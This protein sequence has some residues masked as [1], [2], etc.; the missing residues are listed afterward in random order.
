MYY[1][2]DPE[3]GI[4]F[5]DTAE[6]AKSR[7]EKALDDAQ[8]HAADSDWA[9]NDNEDEISWGE[10]RGKVSYNDRPL[11]ADEKKENPEWDH[12]RNPTLDDI[13]PA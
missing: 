3:D 10:V 13:K 2:Y 11:T 7:A 4:R 8:F 6:E 5:H 1:S 12:I 9:W